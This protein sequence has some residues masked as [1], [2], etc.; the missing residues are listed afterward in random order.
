MTVTVKKV[1]EATLEFFLF[2]PWGVLNCKLNI[3][4]NLL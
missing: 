1:A 3:K 4:V 2:I